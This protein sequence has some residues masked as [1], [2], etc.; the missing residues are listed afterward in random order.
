MKLINKYGNVA[1]KITCIALLVIISSNAH[2]VADN[3]ILINQQ[4]LKGVQ[5]EISK[6]GNSAIANMP[7]TQKGLAKIKL[8]SLDLTSAKVEVE[9]GK[10]LNNI[11]P[12]T[13]QLPSGEKYYLF[14]E[15]VVSDSKQYLSQY[16]DGKPLDINKTISDYNAMS[17]NAKA[18]LG[19]SRML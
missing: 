11:K 10:R 8:E 17:K 13:N 14:S 1:N 9:Q 15:S 6:Q 16:S 12:L 2:A 5:A 4:Q 18:K 19:E 3:T 7:D